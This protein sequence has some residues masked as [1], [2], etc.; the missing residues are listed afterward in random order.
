VLRDDILKK[1]EGKLSQYIK[2]IIA[3]N[4]STESIEDSREKKEILIQLDKF[5][6]YKQAVDK[7]F[8]KHHNAEQK[9]IYSIVVT[10]ILLLIGVFPQKYLFYSKDIAFTLNTAILFY[11]LSSLISIVKSKIE[12]RKINNDQD[13]KC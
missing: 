13:L 2:K 10:I 1:R 5:F 4:G 8:K 6:E 7:H 11:L 12:I 3:T 9:A